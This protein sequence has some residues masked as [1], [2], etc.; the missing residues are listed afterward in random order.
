[1]SFVRAKEEGKMTCLQSIAT[2]AIGVLALGACSPSATDNQAA[3]ANAPATERVENNVAG[4]VTNAAGSE[5][6][7]GESAPG[8]ASVSSGM[9]VPGTQT[10]E[11]VVVNAD[12][13]PTDSNR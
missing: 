5:S 6:S 9:P 10:P 1:M 3:A 4:A 2:A 11:H 7:K 12:G 13:A 8:S